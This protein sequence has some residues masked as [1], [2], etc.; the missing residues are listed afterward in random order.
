MLLL[1]SWASDLAAGDFNFSSDVLAATIFTAMILPASTPDE[2]PWLS[3]P[4]LPGGNYRVQ[5]KND[6]SDTVWQNLP[7]TPTNLGVKSWL[8]DSTPGSS[9]R[10]YRVLS[11]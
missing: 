9:Q 5:F 1:Q 11:Y 6:L 4:I 3:W 2:G 7:G 10:F 8:Q